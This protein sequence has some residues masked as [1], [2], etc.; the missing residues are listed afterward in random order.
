M[1]AFS[2]W[3]DQATS[4]LFILLAYVAVVA[5]IGIFF[6]FGFAA[7]AFAGICIFLAAKFARD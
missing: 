4:G 1:S 6:G 7:L 5:A 3:D 2:G